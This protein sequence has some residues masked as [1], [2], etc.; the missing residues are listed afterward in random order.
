MTVDGML[1]EALYLQ[2]GERQA[3]PFERHYSRSEYREYARADKDDGR[4]MMVRTKLDE[5]A[6]LPFTSL[7]CLLDACLETGLCCMLDSPCC[8]ASYKTPLS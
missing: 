2:A 3:I 8:H 6:Q 5:H 4:G 7:G 1:V